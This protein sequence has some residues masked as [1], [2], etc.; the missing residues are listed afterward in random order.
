MKLRIATR[1]SP[2]AL[3]QARHVAAA[4]TQLPDVDGVDLVLV[5]TTGDQ[6]RDRP[7][8]QIGGD[9]LFTKEVQRALLDGRADVAVHSL[10]DLP[11]EPVAG[12]VL[13]AV[14]PRGPV[15]DAFLSLRQGRFD[16]LP[17]G[18]RVATGSLRRQAQLRWRRPDVQLVHI[19]GNVETRLAKL[20]E[21]DL[22]GLILAEA[23]LVRLGLADRIQ[24]VL[25]PAWMLPA[26]GQGALGIE[27]REDDGP[28]RAHLRN[29]NDP[30]TAD[31]V[32]AERA[33]LHTLGG[34]C[35]LPVGTATGVAGDRLTIRGALLAP[36]GGN[37]LESQR[38]GL[39][40]DSRKLG[41]ELARELMK[42]GGE[43]ILREIRNHLA[44]GG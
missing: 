21:E 4:L 9:G 41:S 19:R 31:C 18:A 16:D 44:R 25:D 38:S 24:E 34:G 33:F 8:T 26:V 5:E 17:S 3:W 6:I 20:R 43:T 40:D 13:G 39:R 32:E 12:I 2:L 29:L 7:L 15:G 28:T 37:R 35:A 36:D 1:G 14:P 30:A 23:G 11:T 42:N 10:K 22:D 27:C